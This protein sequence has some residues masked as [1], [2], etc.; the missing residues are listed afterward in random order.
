MHSLHLGFGIGSLV[1]PQIA[2]PFLAVLNFDYHDIPD[3]NSTFNNDSNSL[4]PFNKSLENSTLHNKSQDVDH[5]EFLVETHVKWAYLIVASIACAVS[6]VFFVFQFC[7]KSYRNVKV[8]ATS[9]QD[10]K[11]SP[12]AMIDPGSCA[13]GDRAY[14]MKILVFL[15][16][17]SFQAFGGE[18]VCSNFLR[19]YTVDH[20]HMA[21][22]D[23]S[24]LNTCFW[25]SYTLGCF[26]GFL[27]AA[28]IPIRR[29]LLL[30]SFG[31][32]ISTILMVLLVGRSQTLL[33]IFIL[34][35]G[36][37]I[38]PAFPVCLVWGDRHIEMTG[39]ALTF[40]LFGGSSGGVTYLWVAGHVYD[41][42]G[43]ETFPY[44]CVFCGAVLC[45]FA[46]LLH[47]VSWK[48]GTRFKE[49]MLNIAQQ[50]DQINAE[51]LYM[52]LEDKDKE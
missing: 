11:P 33:W 4:L 7:G 30:Q 49:S 16:L 12:L 14:G 43:P 18:Y 10:P 23:A 27:A 45:L 6:T 22:D 3:N 34:P 44:M 36:A 5:D 25:I 40:V 2:N 39:M 38:A 31:F 19:T 41:S 26:L 24:I 21:G 32:L 46:V 1:V 8:D 48:R 9:S 15:F 35:V 52:S 29:L 47:A 42:F 13:G 20:H 37:L 28:W 17:F 50:D 51:K